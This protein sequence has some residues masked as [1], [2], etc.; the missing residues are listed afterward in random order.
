MTLLRDLFPWL[1]VAFLAEVLFWNV[2]FLTLAR[3][4]AA[5][6]PHKYHRGA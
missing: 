5:R 1:P 4:R 2:L 3:R 6:K